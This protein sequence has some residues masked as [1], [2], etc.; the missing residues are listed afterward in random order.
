MEVGCKFVEGIESPVLKVCRC[1]N[2][3]VFFN[4]IGERW[5]F[6][7]L[8]FFVC[9]FVFMDAIKQHARITNS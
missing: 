7:G 2:N 6:V 5:V 4:I 8:T 1:P 3:G 9:F